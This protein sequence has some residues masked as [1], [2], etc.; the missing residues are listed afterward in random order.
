MPKTTLAEPAPS[1][2][3]AHILALSVEQSVANW[4]QQV[5]KSRE[6]GERMIQEIKD[7]VVQYREDFSVFHNP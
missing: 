7:A 2:L 3:S 5:D 6:I 1:S 4:N